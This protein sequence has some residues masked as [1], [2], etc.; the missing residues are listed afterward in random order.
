L[1]R[2]CNRSLVLCSYQCVYSSSHSG[3]QIFSLWI[4]EVSRI[5][6]VRFD[7][8]CSRGDI[9]TPDVVRRMPRRILTGKLRKGSET[10]AGYAGFALFQENF[11]RISSAN[12]GATER[13]RF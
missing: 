13:G 8:K 10:S 1:N 11:K 4:Y 2:F 3:N 6:I 7:F 9:L 5:A 12:L